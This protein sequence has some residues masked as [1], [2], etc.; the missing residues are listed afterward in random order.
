MGAFPSEADGRRIFTAEFNSGPMCLE[1]NGDAD[2]GGYG[3]A[4]RS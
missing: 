4:L 1:F 2:G 3:S